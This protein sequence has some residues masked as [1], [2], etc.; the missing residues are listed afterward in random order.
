ML[1][2]TS[3]ASAQKQ[4]DA[5]LASITYGV[6]YTKDGIAAIN[7][8]CILDI[9]QSQSFFYSKNV[10]E[11]M[12]K[13]Q[14]AFEKAKATGIKPNFNASDFVLNKVYKY[15]KLNLFDQ[16]KVVT[17]QSVGNQMLGYANKN[18]MGSN[19]KILPDTTTIKGFKCQKA[20]STNGEI[21]VSAW[22][23]KDIPFNVGPL[24]YFGLPGLILKASTNNGWET[25]LQGIV[26][27]KE[28]QKK[29]DVIDYKLVSEEDFAKALANA[30]AA[31]G[32]GP[33]QNSAKKQVN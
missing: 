8:V 29:L 28:G 4:K 10:S 32:T 24:S 33:S 1:L 16:K 26:Y 12:M 23:C 9:G 17:I 7:D 13:I 30:K 14:D 27:P 2:M 22:F 6:N 31:R 25:T 20:E 18:E 19:W 3:V 21:T 11:S 15:Y 5:V